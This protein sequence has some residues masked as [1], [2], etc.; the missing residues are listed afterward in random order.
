METLTD[1]GKSP[2]SIAATYK[3]IGNAFLTTFMDA[4]VSCLAEKITADYPFSMKL[5]HLPEFYP[6]I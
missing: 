1:S 5:F 3:K 2:G 6:K 4:F